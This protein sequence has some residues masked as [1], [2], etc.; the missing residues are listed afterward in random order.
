[1]SY[2]VC[3]DGPILIP[4][5][6]SNVEQIPQ[7]EGHN[8]NRFLFSRNAPSLDMRPTFNAPLKDGMYTI[9]AGAA[10]GTIAEG[11]RFQ[12][13]N[14]ELIVEK[15]NPFS[16]LLKVNGLI[17]PDLPSAGSVVQISS[18]ADLSV[19][20]SDSALREGVKHLVGDSSDSWRYGYTVPGRTPKIRFVEQE[21]EAQF[22]ICTL[23]NNKIAFNLVPANC[24]CSIDL[25]DSDPHSRICSIIYA[26]WSYHYHLNRQGTNTVSN[27]VDSELSK[28]GKQDQAGEYPR[29]PWIPD[30]KSTIFLSRPS[31]G[32]RFRGVKVTPDSQTRYGIR[33]TNQS[34]KVP[35]YCSV[36]HFDSDFSISRY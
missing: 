1:M 26:A 21:N 12:L 28:L 33:I 11:D 27:V 29:Y 31:Q 6:S 34:S 23:N 19:Y 17:P 15:L 18:L 10:H 35:L 8:R 25:P 4:R 36:F 2:F 9:N 14:L 32:C 22:T 20:V 30:P 7:C 13:K 24:H 5:P 3:L 16:T